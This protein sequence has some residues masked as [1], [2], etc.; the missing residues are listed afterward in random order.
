RLYVKIRAAAEL[1]IPVPGHHA[2][3]VVVRRREIVPRHIAAAVEIRR[4][5]LVPAVGEDGT[6]ALL[7]LI[8]IEVE[9]HQLAAL[10]ERIQITGAPFGIRQPVRALAR[11]EVPV[12]IARLAA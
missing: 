7:Q 12:R 9:T 8:S 2:D 6:I 3:I 4:I 10:V 11:A 1:V 5:A